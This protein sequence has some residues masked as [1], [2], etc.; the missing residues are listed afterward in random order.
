MPV[1]TY[2]TVKGMTAEELTLLG[3]EIIL[4]N[5]FHLMLRPGAEIIDRHGGLHGF[6]H[7]ERPL[8]TD[9][10]GFQVF[11]LAARAQDNAAGSA[12]SFAGERRQGFPGSG[13]I[14]SRPAQSEIRHNHG[15]R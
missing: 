12:F 7:W 10:G 9:S 1:G 15:I 6:M 14:N 5:T 3:T 4:G 11:S 13:G 8:L 2:A